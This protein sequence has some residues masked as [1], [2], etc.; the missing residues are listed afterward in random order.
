MI[1]IGISLSIS[2]RDIPEYFVNSSK[3][4]KILDISDSPSLPAFTL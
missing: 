1:I 3:I 2:D 4:C